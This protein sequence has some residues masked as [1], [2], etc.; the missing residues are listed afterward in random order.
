[1]SKKHAW[2][3]GS[4]LECL[5]LA[6]AR[7][8]TNNIVGSLSPQLIQNTDLDWLIINAVVYVSPVSTDFFLT[9]NN[10]S[11]VILDD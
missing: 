8:E 9:V 3:S 11:W 1:M 5:I 4:I 7:D 6:L 2:L 10:M